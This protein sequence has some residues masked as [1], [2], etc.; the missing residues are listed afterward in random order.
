MNFEDLNAVENLTHKADFLAKISKDPASAKQALIDLKNNCKL[1]YDEVFLMIVRYIESKRFTVSD[2]LIEDL[3]NY[4]YEV[5][6]VQPVYAANYIE[7]SKC[8]TH[9]K[10][11]HYNIK[12][13]YTDDFIK[14]ATVYFNMMFASYY[15]NVLIERTE[16]LE[17]INRVNAIL[18]ESISKFKSESGRY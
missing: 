4:S 13:L 17:E 2:Q 14:C 1:S 9:E 6:E 12:E 5:Y 15:L 7:L 18:K 8:Y 11:E 16:D 3:I 10:I